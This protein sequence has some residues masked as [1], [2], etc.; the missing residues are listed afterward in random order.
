MLAVLM[1]QVGVS[2]EDDETSKGCEVIIETSVVEETPNDV[3]LGAIAGLLVARLLPESS[4][5]VD[6]V[7]GL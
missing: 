7:A 4:A 1:S 6:P 5:R 2:I 3:E